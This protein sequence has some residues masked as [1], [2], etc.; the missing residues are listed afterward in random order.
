MRRRYTVYRM[1]PVTGRKEPIGCVWER[2]RSERETQRNFLALLVE[3]RKL[4]GD[5]PGE[6]IHIVIDHPNRKEQPEE[7]GDAE[8]D[9]AE[10]LEYLRKGER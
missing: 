4:F 2:R 5:G 10:R 8:E 7:T 3:A 6:A 1:E 9:G